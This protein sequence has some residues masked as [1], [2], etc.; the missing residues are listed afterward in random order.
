MRFGAHNW[1][2]TPALLNF[3]LVW[4]TMFEC[5]QGVDPLPLVVKLGTPFGTICLVTKIGGTTVG[6]ETQ[7]RGRNE[8]MQSRMS[9]V[10]LSLL[11]VGGSSVNG[12]ILQ[13]VMAIRGA[14][15]D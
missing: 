6:R 4:Q 5:G 2:L 7:K 15:M 13:G 9:C 11:L 3:S 1:D 8:S 14:E 12:E 10:A